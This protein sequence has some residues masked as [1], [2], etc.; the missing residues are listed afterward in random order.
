MEPLLNSTNV[1]RI[2]NL[3]SRIKNIK[4]TL[5]PP[6]NMEYYDIH[7]EIFR[8]MYDKWNDAQIIKQNIEQIGLDE[9][10]RLHIMTQ[11]DIIS[12]RIHL[13]I[14]SQTVINDISKLRMLGKKGCYA[15]YNTID[16]ILNHKANGEIM[17]SVVVQNVLK[18]MTELKIPPY[19]RKRFF[20]ECREILPT[21][22]NSLP[23]KGRPLPTK[24]RLEMLLSFR[25]PKIDN[26][27]LNIHYAAQSPMPSQLKGVKGSEESSEPLF[28]KVLREKD[29]EIAVLKQRILELENQPPVNV[30]CPECGHLLEIHLN[31][32][33]KNLAEHFESLK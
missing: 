27:L 30:D 25:D 17:G 20:W 24:E 23:Q 9:S 19:I 22:Y 32:E 15:A 1:D 28:R 33:T 12:R 21:I 10:E 7:E 13:L 6:Y 31:E 5:D 8:R 14:S 29:E 16:I 3:C 26:A 18:E 11:P 2:I 4:E